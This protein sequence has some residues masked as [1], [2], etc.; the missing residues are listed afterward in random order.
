MIFIYNNIVKKKNHIV[1]S[2]K[3]IDVELKKRYDALPNLIATAKKY[4][5]F[6]NSLFENVAKIKSNYSSQNQSK[7]QVETEISELLKGINLTIE[8]NPNLKAIDS[9]LLLQR[10]INEFTEQI[11]AAQRNHNASVLSYN[12]A[13]TIFPNNLVAKFFKFEKEN[14]IQI[15]T[16]KERENIDISLLL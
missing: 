15:I 5:E 9:I 3:N 11:S 4:M 13:I 1:F 14:F 7:L 8:S 10:S 6:E 2:Q 16:E 12:N